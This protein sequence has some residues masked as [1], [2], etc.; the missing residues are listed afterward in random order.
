MVYHVR[1]L[2]C[3]LAELARVLLPGGRL[4][5]TTYATDN[6]VELWQLV[7]R[8]PLSV[9]HSFREDTGEEALHRHF[10][11]VERRDVEAVTIFPGAT[12]AREF[13]ASTIQ[14]RHLADRVPE[15]AEPLRV[16][17]HQI[18]FVAEKAA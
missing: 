8:D 7:G 15:I 5:A 18:V 6:F 11:Q 17:N 4:V 1:D 14:W 10:S 2:D 9:R 16:R 13:I 3:A 12:A